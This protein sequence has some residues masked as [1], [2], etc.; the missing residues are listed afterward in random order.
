MKLESR[1]LYIFG[2]GEAVLRLKNYPNTAASRASNEMFGRKN[3]IHGW[4]GPAVTNRQVSKLIGYHHH[5]LGPQADCQA[6]HLLLSCA[7]S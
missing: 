3:T 5:Q 7:A 6:S 1:A 4:S 2:S